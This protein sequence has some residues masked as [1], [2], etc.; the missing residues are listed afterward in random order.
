MLEHRKNSDVIKEL[1]DIP[2]KRVLDVGCGDGGLT[3]FLTRLGGN[4]VGI[5]CNPRQLVKARSAEPV[6]SERYI[7]GSGQD[8]PIPDNSVDIVVFLNSLHHVPVEFQGS[9]LT[10]AARVLCSGGQLF[11]CEPIAE[12]THFEMVK[13][14]DD[15][16]YVRAEALKAI[17]RANETLFREVREERYWYQVI[18]A[19]FEDFA[20]EMTRID[21]SRDALFADRHDELKTSFHAF[22]SKLEDGRYGFEQPM[23]VN[24]LHLTAT[25]T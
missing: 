23:R 8:L 7:E 1:L 13:P 9:A 17:K 6:G 22:G 5:D 4:V 25:D 16:T 21:P 10:E 18:D 11:I 20:E 14:F 12:G 15:E 24:L 2:G 3:R 19:S